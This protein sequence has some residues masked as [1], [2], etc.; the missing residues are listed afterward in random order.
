[1][2]QG[3]VL[4]LHSFIASTILRGNVIYVLYFYVALFVTGVAI[5]VGLP[6]VILVLIMTVL[7]GKEKREEKRM[8]KFLSSIPN[9]RSISETDS[10][11]LQR[12]LPANQFDQ[13]HS[14][15]RKQNT[16]RNYLNS[17][18]VDKYFNSLPRTRPKVPPTIYPS[19]SDYM[20]SPFDTNN[21][22]LGGP[23][24]NLI[25]HTMASAVKHIP[26]EGDY[27]QG[28]QVV[29]RYDNPV[30]KDDNMSDSGL[31]NDGVFHTYDNNWTL[32]RKSKWARQHAQAS[33]AAKA[34]QTWH[35]ENTNTLPSNSKM[36]EQLDS[37]ERTHAYGDRK[38]H[39]YNSL[40][41]TPLEV[42]TFV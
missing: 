33:V 22:I 39:S 36:R 35:N 5:G 3:R 29:H 32:G 23:V 31:G 2:R 18:K 37:S 38:S 4:I 15:G 11:Y 41:H 34:P 8:E 30:F 17:K 24:N 25:S 42:E 10:R 27:S 28:E 26:N 9:S 19:S 1:M 12:Q 14:L 13:I 16:T 7:C 21:G 20:M 6:L 40:N